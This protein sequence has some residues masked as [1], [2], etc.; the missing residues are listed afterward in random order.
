MAQ[1][2][3][4]VAAQ[5]IRGTMVSN[6]SGCKGWVSRGETH[7]YC[8]ALQMEYKDPEMFDYVYQNTCKGKFKT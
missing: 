6:C 3:K 8:T 4:V 7:M 5:A 1:S 2:P